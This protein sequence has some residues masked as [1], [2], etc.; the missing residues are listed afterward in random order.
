[1]LFDLSGSLNSRFEFE[2]QAASRFIK[3]VWREGDAACIVAFS[4][5]PHI[6]L[7]R[8]IF[9]SEVLEELLKLRPT[10]NP[11]AFFD[12]V[13]L[14]TRILRQSATQETRQAVVVLS[15]GA[16]NR[17]EYSLDDTVRELHLSDS[18][19]YAINPSGASVR[20]NKINFEGQKNL[21]LLASATGGTAYVSDTTGDLDK[22]FDRIASELRAQYLLGYYS[23][24]PRLDGKF[25]NIEVSIPD[26]PGL[27]IRARQGYYS[28][29]R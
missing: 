13:I 25:R 1:L 2:Q 24:N 22:I 3:K 10:E 27:H 23:S 19:L 18:V 15:D 6:H 29:P 7:K 28:K 9:I 8:S 20:L 17:S 21:N 4:H 12:S 14:S 16:D 5:K 26:K 11:T